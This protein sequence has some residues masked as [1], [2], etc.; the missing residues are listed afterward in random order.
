MSAEDLGP[1]KYMSTAEYVNK[2]QFRTP[3][4]FHTK[5]KNTQLVSVPLKTFTRTI[6]HSPKLT[7]KTRTRPVYYKSH[8]E[9]EIQ[10]AAEMKK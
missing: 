4:R 10:V 8:E 9:Q 6:P 2:F 7:T 1:K 3:D 5:P